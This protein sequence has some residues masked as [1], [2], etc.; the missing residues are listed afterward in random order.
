MALNMKHYPVY[1]VMKTR[2]AISQLIVNALMSGQISGSTERTKVYYECPSPP[3]SMWFA[4]IFDQPRKKYCWKIRSWPLFCEDFSS[5][6]SRLCTP[7]IRYRYLSHLPTGL[8]PSPEHGDNA[9][10]AYVKDSF[11]APQDSVI[12]SC[13][14][15]IKLLVMPAALNRAPRF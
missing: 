1:G 14:L 7:L 11:S 15:Y 2:A 8:S 10:W 6:A 5:T 3:R 13:R 9:A 4:Y 12:V